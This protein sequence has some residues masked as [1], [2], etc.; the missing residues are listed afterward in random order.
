MFCTGAGVALWLVFV[1]VLT[2]AIV[3]ARK[4]S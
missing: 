1:T 2:A 3:R 4:E